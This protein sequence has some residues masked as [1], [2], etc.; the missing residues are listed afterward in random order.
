M[1]E[2]VSIHEALGKP[3]VAFVS[4][5]GEKIKTAMLPLVIP[6]GSVITVSL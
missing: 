5:M 3:V 2:W 4:L 6:A 1:R